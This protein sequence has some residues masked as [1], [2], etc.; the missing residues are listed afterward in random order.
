M[1]KIR[2]AQLNDYAKVI[3]LTKSQENMHLN[4]NDSMIEQDFYK[5]SL[6]GTDTRWYVVEKSDEVLAY[7]FFTINQM[8]QEINLKKFII[9]SEYTKKGLN[10]HLYRKMEQVALKKGVAYM[11]AEISEDQLDVM[12]FFERKGWNKEVDFYVKYMK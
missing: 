2:E 1:Y 11:K 10:E 5:E 9:G 3:E 8:N 12:D 7:A 4:N 6:I